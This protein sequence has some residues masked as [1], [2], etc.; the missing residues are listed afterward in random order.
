MSPLALIDSLTARRGE[1][2]GVQPYQIP[3]HC[4]DPLADLKL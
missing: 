4:L 2:T 3:L 1:L